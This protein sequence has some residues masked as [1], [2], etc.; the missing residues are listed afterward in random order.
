MLKWKIIFWL[1]A[2]L[3]LVNLI[4][5]PFQNNISPSDFAGLINGGFSLIL[6]YGLAYQI[7]IGSKNIAIAIFTINI[8]LTLLS[9]AE[10]LYIMITDFHPIRPYVVASSIPLMIIFTIPQYFYAFKSENIWRVAV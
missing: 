8:S 1:A 4:N 5:L 2:F 10:L 7:A 9:T 3:A 6:M